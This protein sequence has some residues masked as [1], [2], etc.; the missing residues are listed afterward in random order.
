MVYCSGTGTRTSPPP[1]LLNAAVTQEFVAV[2]GACFLLI[3]PVHF[4][5]REMI[6]LQQRVQELERRLEQR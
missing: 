5:C 4:L 2:Y 3:P 1:A 6:R